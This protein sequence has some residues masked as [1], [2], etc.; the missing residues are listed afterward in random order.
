M[1][2]LN[3]RIEETWELWQHFHDDHLRLDEWLRYMECHT[4]SPCC[5]EPTFDTARQELKKFEVRELL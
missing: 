4:R 5:N 1:S 2:I 3:C